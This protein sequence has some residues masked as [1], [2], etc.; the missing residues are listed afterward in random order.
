[1]SL[2][3]AFNKMNQE[4]ANA[5][6]SNYI[7]PFERYIQNNNLDNTPTYS[8]EKAIRNVDLSGQNVIHYNPLQYNKYDIP[9]TPK[10][11][12][13]ELNRQRAINQSFGE[14]LWRF[15]V[16]TVGDQIVLG[17]LQAFTDMGDA[18]LGNQGGDYSNPLSAAIEEAREAIRE[19]NEIYRVNPGESFDL[20][21]SGWWLNGATS[22]VSS[23][24]LMAPGLA[25][26]KGVGL[27]AK[28]INATKGVTKLLE[29]YNTVAKGA[30][31]GALTVNSARSAQ[32]IGQGSE[33]LGM[34]AVSRIAE[35]YQEARQT[36]TNS[37]D[38]VMNGLANMSNEERDEF[39]KNNPEFANKSDREIAELIAGESADDV[40]WKDMYLI[41][42]DAIQLKA[43]NKV[44]KGFQGKG[45]LSKAVRDEERKFAAQI[46]GKT[47][48]PLTGFKGF[49]D[50]MKLMINPKIVLTEATEGLEES[51]QYTTQKRAEENLL[52]KLNPKQQVRGYL[53]IITDEESLEN[54]FWGWI[55][56][57]TFQGLGGAT[58]RGINAYQDKR[59][60]K[61]HPEDAA[62]YNLRRQ[63]GVMDSYRTEEIKSRISE[64]GR[65]HELRKLVDDG[66]D[67][68]NYRTD[69]NNNIITDQEGNVVYEPLTDEYQGELI[70]QDLENDMLVNIAL[71]AYDRGNYNAL[72]ETVKD[73]NFNEQDKSFADRA[74]S[75]MDETVDMY[76]KELGMAIANSFSENIARQIALNNVKAKLKI[77]NHEKLATDFGVH[78]EDL[79]RINNYSGDDEKEIRTKLQELELAYYKEQLEEINYQI[80]DYKRRYNESTT[81]RISRSTFL[82]QIRQLNRI[83]NII[84]NKKPELKQLEN[85]RNEI[86][87][88]ITS[89]QEELTNAAKQLRN[90]IDVR[91]SNLEKT[92][93][94]GMT[95]TQETTDNLNKELI[96]I[97][98]SSKKSYDDIYD[99]LSNINKEIADAK[100]N[101]LTFT[102]RA[103]ING[104]EI[105][106]TK[107]EITQEAEFINN[108]L[109]VFRDKELGDAD[110][111]INDI[112]SNK[113]LN[114]E[115]IADEL[116][117]RQTN[118]P[119]EVK[120]RLKKAIEKYNLYSYNN[121]P[122]LDKI[123]IKLRQE[124]RKRE[125]APEAV[126]NDEPVTEVPVTPIQSEASEE[127][128]S[129]PVEGETQSTSSTSTGS[130][131]QQSVITTNEG[132]V[133]VSEELDPDISPE[134]K[135]NLEAITIQSQGDYEVGKS[136]RNDI[137]KALSNKNIDWFARDYNTIF[138]EIKQQLL[139]KYNKEDVDREMKDFDMQ[140]YE[141]ISNNGISFE[142]AVQNINYFR[143]AIEESNS[144]LIFESAAVANNNNLANEQLRQLYINL[145][146]RYVEKNNIVTN[147]QRLYVNLDELIK[148]LIRNGIVDRTTLR[149]I[150]NNMS[151]FFRSRYNNG[152]TIYKLKYV[153][154]RLSERKLDKLFNEVEAGDNIGQDIFK[155]AI[156][157]TA[158][159]R[160]NVINKELY[161]EAGTP[162]YAVRHSS[163]FGIDFY[164]EQDG[165][166]VQI[167]YN[168]IGKR[169]ANG[170]GYNI[171][172]RGINYNILNE[173]GVYTSDLDDIFTTLFPYNEN[174]ENIPLSKDD[175]KALNA[176]FDLGYEMVNLKVNKKFKD[177]W[178]IN[179]KEQIEDILKCKI[180]NDFLSKHFSNFATNKEGAVSSFIQL[181]Y[182]IIEFSR[183]SGLNSDLN[184]NV[185]ILY[186]DFIIR[187]IS[188]YDFT[189]QLNK[190]LQG[191]PNTSKNP[192]VVTL[193]VTRSQRGDPIEEGELKP[194]N[195]DSIV[196]FNLDKSD[197][198]EG[199][200]HL[201]RIIDK[202]QIK[203]DNGRIHNIPGFNRNL[204]SPL[205]LA[206][207]NGSNYPDYIPIYASTINELKDD[208]FGKDLLA[209]INNIFINFKNGVIDFDTVYDRLKEL[210][211]PNKLIQDMALYKT[212]DDKI[213]ISYYKNVGTN[214]T[215]DITIY[216]RD[217]AGNISTGISF[218]NSDGNV[219]SGKQLSDK[220]INDFISKLFGIARIAS[221]YDYFENVTIDTSYVKKNNKEMIIT[222]NNHEYK[223]RNYLEFIS[224]YKTG[225]I[226]LD[227]KV[228][229]G[230]ETNFN[231]L[232]T[233]QGANINI[234]V[235]YN[236]QS[237]NQV[238]NRV[239]EEENKNINDF[240]NKARQSGNNISINK[241][242]PKRNTKKLLELFA[243][244]YVGT[245]FNSNGS[246][247]TIGS[248][249]LLPTNF[250]IRAFDE[251]GDF[252]E[253]DANN[254]N[255]EVDASYYENGTY[256]ITTKL[257]TRVNPNDESSQEEFIRTLLHERVHGLIASKAGKV[258]IEEI[259]DGINYIID[260]LYEFVDNGDKLSQYALANNL[261]VDILRNN[262]NKLRDYIN[263][264]KRNGKNDTA[265]E[266]FIAYT[267]TNRSFIDL[268][269]N[270]E[271][272][273]VEGKK[274]LW[275]KFIDFIAKLFFGNDYKINE[276][277]L[278]NRQIRLLS[279][280]ISNNKKVTNVS[281]P[282]QGELNFDNAPSTGNVNRDIQN[283]QEPTI[284]EPSE[285]KPESVQEQYTE[286][287]EY[288]AK[289]YSDLQSL[290]DS[291][292][293][294]FDLTEFNDEDNFND[295]DNMASELIFED[296]QVTNLSTVE[297]SLR[298]D[299]R[300]EFGTLASAG[301]IKLHC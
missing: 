87:N 146:E 159:K 258:N 289:E 41:A 89:L 93:S 82:K 123:S 280:G 43:L 202:G 224:K 265:V 205:L 214:K 117:G 135:A 50:D 81:D 111:T 83:K 85:R 75:K 292:S 57:I 131:T 173:N 67:V 7:N 133:I 2:K 137:R 162:I 46:S 33:V 121:A 156:D 77:R 28:A 48:E 101:E 268:L 152:D 40:F 177:G 239:Q 99:E 293:D 199:E 290:A 91:D 144:S 233:N 246:I 185:V 143:K 108:T 151:L 229:N 136:I 94:D 210:I 105:L 84:Y 98:I 241:L 272:E 169:S 278:L 221:N 112:I 129:S 270:I 297:Q 209:E 96:D 71:N 6:G 218:T 285:V 141:S 164:V 62:G 192:A 243:P 106:N 80:E 32:I 204:G 168:S 284:G 55:G 227:K 14:Q 262:L 279:N 298:P 207:S 140:L 178:L 110:K 217:N 228:I 171:T 165:K 255:K 234:Q 295:L 150:Y 86:D 198:S 30:K 196:G 126:K 242:L 148:Y 127:T 18:L 211:G 61:K 92:L 181:I 180:I 153:P 31:L 161:L 149:N 52:N 5:A 232:T 47:Y 267:L 29:G 134:D 109:R 97:D 230:K 215:A 125:E 250:I 119:D 193:N 226:Q 174:Y 158:D 167:G 223:A 275:D 4:P 288:T 103:L 276:R 10:S 244:N 170:N 219:T 27:L 26:T 147:S 13:D 104:G 206:L 291:L 145:I 287:P 139:N 38:Q 237:G 45:P 283:N 35:N 65:Y 154:F 189:N 266:E 1:M 66:Y 132:E 254:P 182:P 183:V 22:I 197:N 68:Y 16:Q 138:N 166:M 157:P 17:T 301:A 259:R 294:D 3:D 264:L 187:Q 130:Q 25:V 300:T 142:D 12:I 235:D 56:G 273:V 78:I 208:D 58:M 114:L 44:W 160:I 212:K 42:F 231:P 274:T 163:G 95:K 122:I 184:R 225:K 51:W 253:Y 245:F 277:S 39:D 37:I 222:L 179:Y 194:I 72:K 15:G 195:A 9:V 36:Y 256:E 263:N 176:I 257:L 53:D 286:T 252:I 281:T 74:I 213:I 79:M 299:Q 20:T 59:Y 172:A 188:N 155:R 70:K 116:N 64:I 107:N 115:E 191:M 282:I 220:T 21:D 54:A 100:N 247:R 186:K 216:K 128:V 60:K 269:N 190:Q 88:Q 249:G 19:A 118:L 261:N 236:E 24:A 238:D 63:E 260:K 8:S 200:V 102:S 248:V 251:N 11:N 23:L 201:A 120:T 76:E 240:L 296:I 90:A 49:V 69:E 124:A 73:T 34:A 175:G 203:L 113:D 271:D